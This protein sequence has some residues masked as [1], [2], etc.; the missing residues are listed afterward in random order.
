[1]VSETKKPDDL[2][3]TMPKCQLLFHQHGLRL[4]SRYKQP[5][6][7]N[8]RAEGTA[9]CSSCVTSV[10]WPGLP[11]RRIPEWDEGLP[12]LGEKIRIGCQVRGG[13]AT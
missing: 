3:G 9:R 6:Q 10:G 13:A 1:M 12:L 8:G 2:S 5:L 11:K 7:P 4:L